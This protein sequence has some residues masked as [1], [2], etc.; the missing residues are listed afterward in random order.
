MIK[1][2]GGLDMKT[3]NPLYDQLEK[4][5]K[6]IELLIDQ[7]NHKWFLYLKTDFIEKD[8]GVLTRK[9]DGIQVLDA[10]HIITKEKE[11]IQIQR[12]RFLEKKDSSI[13]TS[14]LLPVDLTYIPKAELPLKDITGYEIV[15]NSSKTLLLKNKEGF[16]TY[17]DY[18]INSRFY[19]LNLVPACLL[20]AHPFD[21]EYEGYA[22]VAFLDEFGSSKEGYLCRD[23][24]AVD[25][26]AKIQLYTKE[27]IVGKPKE[28]RRKNF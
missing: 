15:G 10:L 24:F 5:Y 21:E 18:N 2:V 13:D 9:Y 16:Y 4:A 22:K 1:L 8:A 19:M 25:Q 3:E 28:K 20:D 11:Q 27:E 26:I 23:D 12:F 17:L 14:S 6:R 7:I